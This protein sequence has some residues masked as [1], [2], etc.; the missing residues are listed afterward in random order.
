MTEPQQAAHT[1][2]EKAVGQDESPNYLSHRQIMS[3]LAGLMM[4]MFLSAL[5]Q[6][7]VATSIRTIGDDLH[8]LSLQAWVTTAYLIT[9]T[10]TTPLYGKLSDIYGRKPLFLISIATFVGGSVM[11]TFSQ[12]MYQLAGFRAVQ[13]IGAGGLFSL[14]LAIIGDIVP[15]RERAKYQGAFLAVFGTASV[16]GP[17]VGG[18]FA[19]ANSILGIAG[20]RW[21][22]LVNVPIGL[23]ALLVVN[24]TL[25]VPHKRLD[26]R[27]DWWGALALVVGLVPLLTIAEQGR[28]WG[29]GSSGA[30]LCYS[31]GVL[32]IVA[33]VLVQRA[34]GDEALLPLRF[35]SNRTFTVTNIVG[36]IMGAAMFGGLAGL[37]LYLQIVKSANPTRAGLLLIPLTLGIMLGSISSGQIIS[38]TGKYKVFPLIGAST[39]IVS[40][41]LLSTVKVDTSLVLTCSLSA[42]FGYGLGNLLQPTVL[43]VQ[44][45]VSPRDIGVATSSATFFR[46]MGGTLGT[47]VFLSV[48]FN[49]WAGRS[50]KEFQTAAADPNSA[51]SLATRNPQVLGQPQ[52]KAYLDSL[53]QMQQNGGKMGAGAFNDTSFLRGVDSGLTRPLFNAFTYGM[54]HIFLIAAGGTVIALALLFF[55]PNIPL[56]GRGAGDAPAAG[57]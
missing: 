1:S 16:L 38:R 13:G 14:A 49:Q 26:H 20:W 41:S 10:I 57:H 50:G 6:T 11:C 47:A 31:L 28:A 45:A 40:L 29:W 8:G 46:Q 54:Q 53:A 35:F 43:A 2:S 51:F 19:G 33:F 22:F 34:M 21:V 39:L 37:P 9:A 25:H 52:N 23:A 12:S 7:I 48:L 42:L 15:P 44:N 56:R 5:D 4:G 27:I 3:V 18:F 17:L 32:G 36:V 55:L 30:L 24:A